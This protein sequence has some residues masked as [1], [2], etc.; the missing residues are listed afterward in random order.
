MK[1]HRHLLSAI[2]DSLHLILAEGRPADQVVATALKQHPKWG[3]RDRRL[4]A[5]STYDLV[6]W[7]RWYWHLAGEKPETFR[8]GETISEGALWRVWAAYWTDRH[9]APPGLPETAAV[10]LECVAALRNAKVSRAVRE[11]VPDWLDTLG[12]R[13]FGNH[14]PALLHELNQSADVFLR[15]NPLRATAESVATRLAEEGIATAPVEEVPSALRLLERKNLAQA[16]VVREGWCEVQDANS[17][18]IAPMMEVSPGQQVVDACAGAGGKTLHLAAIMENRGRIVACD[19]A[20]SKLDELLRRAQRS[21][22]EIIETHL[23]EDGEDLSS[24]AGS[25]DRLLLDVPCSGSGVL[26]R[27]VDAKWRLSPEELGRLQQLQAHIL[28]SYSQVVKPSGKMLYATCSLLPDENERQITAFL[29]ET[30]AVWTLEEQHTWLPQP[31]GGD[32]FFAARLR[33]NG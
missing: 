17:Q 33:R 23:L 18:R 6:R 29:A 14:W 31:G 15:V 16:A 1:L 4:V 11:S 19:V 28:R 25:A 21:G 8:P 2:Q 24:L 10:T 20:Q 5:E 26:R 13:E 3:A 22:V 32:G 12:E 7:F 9:G 27:Q 30:G